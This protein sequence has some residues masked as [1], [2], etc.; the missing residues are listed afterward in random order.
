M[1]HFRPVI[2]SS[3]CLGGLAVAQSA[4]NAASRNLAFPANGPRKKSF[5][6]IAFCLPG[7]L[8]TALLAQAAPVTV[9]LGLSAQNFTMAGNG[10][11][12]A[13]LG[14]Y[15]ITIGACSANLGNTTCTLSGSF[16]GTTPGFTAGTYIL[17]TTY[18]GTG[19][20]PFLGVEQAA[21]SNLFAFSFAPQTA[22]MTLNLTSS[23]GTV[24]VPLL[25]AGQL[26]AGSTFSLVYRGTPT[27]RG[28]P[29]ST[30]AVAQV[31][32]T[33][34]ANITGPVTGTATFVPPSQSYYFSQLAFSGGFQTTLTYVNYSP[35]T[36]TCLT[37]FYGDNGSPLPIPFSG[38]TSSS[39]TDTLQ[40]GQVIH[41]QTV[42]VL[43]A[44]VA[45]GWAQATC[46]GPVQ[47]SVLYRFYQEGAPAGEA[48][49]SAETAPTTKFATFAETR[50]G[51]AYANPSTTDS[52]MMTLTAISSAGLRL[53]STTITLGPL[54]HGAANIGPLLGLQSFTG[55]IEITSTIPIISLSLNAEVFPVFSS[56]PPGD[57]P[58]STTFVSP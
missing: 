32:L 22:T 46:N 54:A 7:L 29:V 13:G 33:A 45:Q 19:P 38:G 31:G 27:C 17:A 12:M 51:V 16:T 47:A 5:S 9:N 44:P 23:T 56:L 21:G 58:S 3:V 1:K 10:P 41:D 49:V 14:Q 8:L 35:Q 15:V 30:C 53:G 26:V 2:F 4:R 11:N 6:Q 55:F 25:A 52:A 40:P 34:G 18:V 48:S 43:G 20:S 39:R 28:T 50:T 36:V 37:N 42:A 24:V 57:L